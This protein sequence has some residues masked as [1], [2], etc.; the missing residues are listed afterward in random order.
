MGT[1]YF[2]QGSVEQHVATA[3]PHGDRAY[4][5]AELAAH[6]IA[7]DPHGDRAYAAALV[8]AL[9]L[10]TFLPTY[11]WA[12]LPSAAANNGL[13]VHVSDVGEGGS[14]WKSNGTLWLPVN[15]SVLLAR[16]AVAASVTGTAAETALATITIPAGLMGTNGQLRVTQLWTVTNSANT[17]TLRAR[18]GGMSGIIYTNAPLTTSGCAQFLT[19]I[20]NRGAANSQVGGISTGYVATSG[21]AVVSAVDTSQATTIVLSGQLA[22]VGE[23]ITLESYSVELLR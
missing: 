21:S 3:D 6:L 14:D 7:A 5:A 10:Q 4:S 12:T 2:G 11:T 18:F 1:G 23:T 17:K 16:S 13:R 20:R 22:S 8:A 15:G 9:N 19:Q